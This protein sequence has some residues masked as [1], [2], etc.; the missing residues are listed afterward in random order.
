MRCIG[1]AIG[2]DP[3]SCCSALRRF[4]WQVKHN[5]DV[6]TAKIC[7]TKGERNDVIRVQTYIGHADDY[8]RLLFMRDKDHNRVRINPARTQ[9]V[10]KMLT[11]A[12]Y[13]LTITEDREDP[14]E[15][16]GPP[17]PYR[18]R[19]ARECKFVDAVFRIVMAP[20][21]NGFD[22]AK[23]NDAMLNVHKLAFR[24][25]RQCLQKNKL[26]EI[27]FATSKCLGVDRE[28]KASFESFIANTIRQVA[29]PVGASDMLNT[30]LSNNVQL[31]EENVNDTP[32][33]LLR[34][35]IFLNRTRCI[36]HRYC[37]IL[38]PAECSAILPTGSSTSSSS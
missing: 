20:W 22:L 33:K 38:I 18:Q 12:V 23:M 17:R 26:S 16:D 4:S 32:V 29:E 21:I 24:V 25:I 9:K 27:Y 11:E 8:V 19:I 7:R 14:L 1:T 15:D 34:R 31:L 30:L 6:L 35:T 13:F 10:T 5:E 2:P 28:W 3:H 37:R 36:L